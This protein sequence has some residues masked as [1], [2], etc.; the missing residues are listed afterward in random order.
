VPTETDDG[1]PSASTGDYCEA[2]PTEALRRHFRCAWS[3]RVAADHAGPITV[4][5]DGC[6]D[7]VWRGGLLQV[8]GPDIEAA[9]PEPPAGSLILGMR[10]AAGAA[11]RWLGLPMSELVG[12]QVPL[13][14]LWGRRAGELA[15][16]IGAARGPDQ[17][18]R[19]FEAGLA[20]QAG[21]IETP[22]DDMA[23]LFAA[24]ARGPVSVDVLAD[25]LALS[26]RTLRRRS[27]EAFGYGPK[28]LERILRFQR[29]LR[30]QRA[31][32]L[33]GLAEIGLAAGYADQ[34]HLS[35]EVR[36]LS[37]LTPGELRRRFAA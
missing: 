16:R 12:R 8:A 20:S 35:R 33:A 37:G 24:L 7:I 19:Q 5:P 1:P 14:E 22:P 28:T 15:D 10:F 31:R 9:L 6:V 2:T 18:L 29:F 21:A 4:V 3:H 13:A 23:F 26:P 30:L 36:S 34:A 25:R 32:P 11:A 27:C 17:Q